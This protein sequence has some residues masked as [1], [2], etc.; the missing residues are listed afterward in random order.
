MVQNYKVR[1]IS[2]KQT[3]DRNTTRKLLVDAF[4]GEEP[5]TGKGSQASRYRYNVEVIS[6]GELV[7]LIRPAWLKAG[8]DFVIH[9]EGSIFGNGKDN[10]AHDDIGKD[11]RAKA[12]ESTELFD[13]LYEALIRVHN[14]EDPEDILPEY[15]DLHFHTG[16]A[17]EDILKIVKW[18]FIEQDIRYW[19]YSGRGMFKSGVI[20]EAMRLLG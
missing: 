17:V 18:F 6:G 10:P 4:I 19:N 12:K 13:R 15:E 11:L 1:S 14:C 9:V 5:G 7:Y 16:M 2:I 20:D 8:F 3:G